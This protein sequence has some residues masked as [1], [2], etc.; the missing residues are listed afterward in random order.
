MTCLGMPIYGG[1]PDSQLERHTIQYDTLTLTHYMAAVDILG[2]PPSV[3]C[4][5]RRTR[6]RV[7]RD[8]C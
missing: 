7:H 3:C 1:Y 6:Q 2:R 5:V 4:S 8:I